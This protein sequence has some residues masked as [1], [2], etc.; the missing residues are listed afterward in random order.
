MRSTLQTL[1]IG[2]LTVVILSACQ[3]GPAGPDPGLELKVSYP[4]GSLNLPTTLLK[5]SD[6][7]ISGDSVRMTF[8]YY[9]YDT[10]KG[11]E[12]QFNDV[13]ISP[14]DT[15]DIVVRFR[16]GIPSSPGTFDWEATTFNNNAAPANADIKQGVVVR[17]EGRTYFPTEGKTVVTEVFKHPNGNIAGIAGYFNGRLQAVWPSGFIPSPSKLVPDGYNVA[18]PSLVGE[19][20][21][22]H[23]CAFSN[24]SISNV[25]VGN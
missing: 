5:S 20:L 10:L 16:A 9:M 22:V 11:A 12:A 17:Y 8:K 19:K 21:T 7:V 18:S 24:R 6:M 4:S 2:M 15:P 14:F 1:F 25:S 3:T 23:S 13:R